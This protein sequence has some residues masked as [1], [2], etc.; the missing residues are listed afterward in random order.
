MFPLMSS[1]P[2]VPHLLSGASP[3]LYPPSIEGDLPECIGLNI[4]GVTDW[5]IKNKKKR[6]RERKRE[7]GN[8]DFSSEVSQPGV[9]CLGDIVWKKTCKRRKEGVTDWDSW[10]IMSKKQ[11]ATDKQAPH[12]SNWKSKMLRLKILSPFI[13]FFKKTSL[14]LIGAESMCFGHVYRGRQPTTICT[15]YLLHS[16][17]LFARW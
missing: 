2:A 10:A 8:W 3:P 4:W 15:L 6:E 14:P 12:I 13:Y 9:E 16:V 11:C 5:M 1:K 7:K 17:L